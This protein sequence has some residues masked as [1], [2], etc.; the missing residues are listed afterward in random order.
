MYENG[1]TIEKEVYFDICPHLFVKHGKII[2][3]GL[4]LM[5]FSENRILNVA[6]WGWIGYLNLLS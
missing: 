1:G 2:W 4:V 6:Q 5:R 3:D